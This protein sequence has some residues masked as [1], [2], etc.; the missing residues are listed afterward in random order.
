MDQQ[1]M[2]KTDAEIQREAIRELSWDTRVSATDIG[3]QVKG[4]VVTLMGHVDSWAKLQ[5]AE[6]AAHRV[7]GVLDVANDV[8]V[9]LPGSTTRTDTDIAQAI[10]RVL[11]WDVTV[12]DKQ[13]QS[14]VS[15]GVVTLE[16]TVS[17][18]S[19]RADAQRAI[20]R[21]AGIKSVLNRIEVK[22]G[23]QVNVA[24]AR[25]AVESALERHAERE[26]SR[27]DL[28]ATDGTVTVTGIVHTWQEKQA[29]LGAVRGTRGVRSIS[30]HLSIEA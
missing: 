2:K 17:F 1:Q 10:R 24:E 9:R 30:D 4:G 14:T 3:V 22:P 16:G 12:P 26:A 21:L 6:E 11:E 13:I 15:N 7:P 27:I 5:A 18:W 25:S 28:R 29:V 20:E 19:Q 23:E 8:V